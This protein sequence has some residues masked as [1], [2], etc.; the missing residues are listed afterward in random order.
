MLQDSGLWLANVYL[1][2]KDLESRELSGRLGSFIRVTL[3]ALRTIQAFHVVRIRF[4]SSLQFM[5][6]IRSGG[7]SL[8]AGRGACFEIRVS[9]GKHIPMGVTRVVSIPIEPLIY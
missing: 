3:H 7:F 5:V 1:E 8:L 2:T 4:N 9:R 6:A